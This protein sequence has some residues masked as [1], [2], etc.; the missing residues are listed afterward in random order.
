MKRIIPFMLMTSLAVWGYA[1][2]SESA[3]TDNG[4]GTGGGGGGGGGGEQPGPG[5]ETP[6]EDL[7]KINPIEGIAPA[8]A[9]LESGGYTDGPVWHAQL[10]VL[11]FSKPYGAGS[12]FRMLPDG[13][14]IKV[15]DGVQGETNPI[16]N[17]VAPNGDLITAEYKRLVRSPIGDKGIPGEPQVIATGY[18]APADPAAPAAGTFDTL[19]EVT[20]GKDGTMYVTDPG[21]AV[22]EPGAKANRIY[23]IAPDGAVQVVEAFEDVPRPNG[24]A[25]DRDGAHLYVVFSAPVVG[26]APF[27]RQYLVNPDGTLGEWTKFVEIGP[28]AT[29]DVQGLA[30]D[31]A[32]NVYV[33]TAAG[34]QVFKE[35]S[36]KIGDIQ[37]PEKPSGMTFG[38]KD[39]K[40]MYVTTWGTKIFELKLKVPGISQ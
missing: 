15:R 9:V 25:L 3:D 1:C 37:L 29:A 18:A 23:R 40:S 22:P 14:V 11:F 7:Q 33:A 17:A 19:K 10:G 6:K 31:L 12:L 24:I 39:M 16:G 20:V 8:K 36:T 2:K 4:D 35:D 21:Y 5:A 34:I 27:I 30:V 38:G 26:T 32:N 13:R 28:D